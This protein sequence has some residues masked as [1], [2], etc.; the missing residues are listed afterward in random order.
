[1][2]CWA[3]SSHLLTNLSTSGLVAGASDPRGSR[4]CFCGSFNG[5]EHQA[6]RMLLAASKVV[7]PAQQSIHG[8]PGQ[9]QEWNMKMLVNA[10][11][12]ILCGMRKACVAKV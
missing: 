9:T 4:K 11:D 12:N 2:F 6:R 10:V 7:T 3:D 8:L 1:M 5:N